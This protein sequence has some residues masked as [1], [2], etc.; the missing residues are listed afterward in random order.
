MMMNEDGDVIENFLENY[1]NNS[2]IKT[3]KFSFNASTNALFLCG[4]KTKG[5][6]SS[7]VNNYKIVCTRNSK[8]A[9]FLGVR[10]DTDESTDFDSEEDD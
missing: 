6:K 7:D 1:F 10:I 8:K 5:Y 9:E 2:G 3:E 4:G